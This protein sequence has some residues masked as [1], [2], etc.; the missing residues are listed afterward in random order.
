ML[1]LTCEI[2]SHNG[3]GDFELD[4]EDNPEQQSKQ[5]IKKRNEYSYFSAFYLYSKDLQVKLLFKEGDDL[6]KDQV[7]MQIFKVF[8][9]LCK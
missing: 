5:E 6:R 2:L 7:V 4:N 8:D 9:E 1:I 3:S